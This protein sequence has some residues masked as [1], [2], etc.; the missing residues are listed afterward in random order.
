MGS[1]YQAEQHPLG[2]AVAIKF[3]HP[4]LDHVAAERD[5]FEKRFNTEAGVLA[6]LSDGNTVAIYDYGQTDDGRSYLVME[7]VE[8][9]PLSRL[10][11]EEAPLEP[12]RA[13]ELILQVCCA[14]RN[15][16]RQGIIHRDLKPSNLLIKR[17][18]DGEEL[19]KVV[20]FG[21]AKLTRDDQTITLDGLILGS[22]HYMSPEQVKGLDVDERSDIYAVGVL[23]YRCVTGR[24]PF[25][26]ANSTATMLEH[27]QK[28]I[29]HLAD[30]LPDKV[31]PV[32][33]EKLIHR[34]MAK[35]PADRFRDV[36]TLMTA[37][38]RLED[39]QAA[40]VESDSLEQTAPITPLKE[41]RS[42]ALPLFVAG[43]A[44]IA[45]LI[46]VLRV[47][48]WR[49]ANSDP[50]A[51]APAPASPAEP[52]SAA[53]EP[54]SS[55]QPE[56]IAIMLH[57]TSQPPQA[58]VLLDGSSIGLTPFT[59]ETSLV[60]QSGG[61]EPDMHRLQFHKEGY[62]GRTL[63]RDLG[64]LRDHRIDVQ[65]QPLP[66]APQPVSVKEKAVEEE[67]VKE[68]VPAAP[69]ASDAPPEVT[70]PP[71]EASEPQTAIEAPAAPAPPEGYKKSPYD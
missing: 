50:V 65:L 68:A 41:R 16:H 58:E 35:R 62:Q 67:A 2:R 38:K 25:H 52:L 5:S 36:A 61:S 42:L 47:Q 33:L 4:P 13:C 17:E 22:P 14:L 60:F 40:S 71:A 69:T 63:D 7:Y 9:K 43:V 24:P 31:F 34:C 51:T 48:A 26:G 49:S 6:K 18:N 57:L 44:L 54:G 46:A 1:V 28:P 45:L 8:G 64:S 12:L 32:G 30:H 66:S 59:Y 20:D 23:L 56:P 10:L 70:E 37:I 53:P 27:L 29:P 39:P 19:V 3:L 15:A 55:S 11:K 21:L